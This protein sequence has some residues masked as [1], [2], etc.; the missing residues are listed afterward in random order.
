MIRTNI[1]SPR[2]ASG[3]SLIEILVVVSLIAILVGISFPVAIKML[4]QSESAQ[5]RSMLLGLAAAADDYNV[6][7]GNVVDHTANTDAFGNNITLNVGQPSP[8]TGGNT[9]ATLGYFVFTAGQSSTSADLI[10]IAAK[11]DL[12]LNGT[13]MPNIADQIQN[14]SLNLGTIDEVELMDVWDNP[15]RYAGGVVHDT[16]TGSFTDDDYL[17]AHPTAFFAS[18][19]PDGEWGRVVFGTNEPDASV[20]NDGDGVADAADNIYSFQV[21]Q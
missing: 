2:R 1:Q 8:N 9:D 10:A 18:A 17:P 5:T 14:G 21:D 13:A 7:T 16:G 12:T 11:N 20:D 3:F 19:G 4:A 15:I 6:T